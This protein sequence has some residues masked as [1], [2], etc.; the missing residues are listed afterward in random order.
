VKECI[1]RL[2]VLAEKWG[3]NTIC[4]MICC[5]KDFPTVYIPLWRYKGSVTVG[6]DLIEI[7]VWLVEKK[8]KGTWGY[9]GLYRLRWIVG[10]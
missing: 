7:K 10:N 8:R 2:A 5:L 3:I 1:R 9:G 4:C 6:P